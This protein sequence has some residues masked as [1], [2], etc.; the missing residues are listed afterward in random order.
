M[1]TA[2]EIE[3]RLR[4]V[5]VEELGRRLTRDVLPHLCSHNLRHPLDHR[6]TVYDEPNPSY[7]R[8]AAGHAE[9][10]GS[11]PVLQ[12]IG[13]C[14]LG[15]ENPEEWPGNVCE[16][17][18]DAQRWPYFNFKMSRLEVYERFVMDLENPEWVEASLPEV[19]QLLWV[20]GSR[21]ELA[22]RETGLV[23]LW[24]WWKRIL[25]KSP[26]PERN[27]GVTVYLPALDA[28]PDKDRS[29]TPARH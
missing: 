23:R 8:I 22:D 28:F 25:V 11:L 13:L 7:N 5:L 1:K 29:R 10:N 16:E 21:L 12:T 24:A 26:A 4:E 14:M 3:D 6:K 9:G 19:C 2:Q 17:P 15:S 20:L 27:V 18:I